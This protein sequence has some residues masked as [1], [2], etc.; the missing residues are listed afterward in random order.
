MEPLG[1]LAQQ[2]R[3]V[4]Q[5]TKETTELLVRLDQQ[6]QLDHEEKLAL[7]Q[8]RVRPDR[9]VRGVFKAYKEFKVNKESKEFKGSKERLDLQAI[10]EA[11]ALQE[12]LARLDLKEFLEELD[13]L[14]PLD[15]LVKQD[16]LEEL[17][18][19]AQQESTQTT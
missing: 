2:D 11:R 18:L 15:Q 6:A 5:A 3:K 1:Q 13:R 8:A 19:P 4:Q 14:A 10:Q 17:D 7:Q 9:L 12:R 16:P